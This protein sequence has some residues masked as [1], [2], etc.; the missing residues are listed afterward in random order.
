MYLQVPLRRSGI[1]KLWEITKKVSDWA[2]MSDLRLNPGKTQAITFSSAYNVRYIGH[3]D[4]PEVELEYGIVVPFTKEVISLRVVL[5][6]TLSWKSQIDRVA[7]IVKV[8]R[9]LYIHRLG[10]CTS[11]PSSC[12]KS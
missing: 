9:V 5:D 1:A 6:R 4:L 3:I 8:N 11:Q 2:T 7:R 12:T 10:L